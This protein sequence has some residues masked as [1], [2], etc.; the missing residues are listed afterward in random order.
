MII[1]LGWP[2][3]TTSSSIPETWAGSPLSLFALL[4]T[5]F[6]WPIGHPIA[7]GLLHHL[8]TLALRLCVLYSVK[9]HISEIAT[10]GGSEKH[11]WVQI[12]L[13][14]CCVSCSRSSAFRAVF[15]CG[16][17]LGF[18]PLVV[19][20]RP[21]LWSPDFPRTAEAARNHPVHFYSSSSR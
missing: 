11:T 7:G 5:G 13:R 6:A 19:S 16:T 14:I 2:L 9:M 4:R 3:P 1:P 8:C 10:C 15:F 17:V 18:P 20:Q 12:V 21:A